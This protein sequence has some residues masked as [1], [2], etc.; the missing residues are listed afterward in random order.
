MAN[1]DPGRHVT[2]TRTVGWKAG[3]ECYAIYATSGLTNGHPHDPSQWMKKPCAVLD[4]FCGSGT[5]GVVAVQ[6][7]RR[8]IGIELNLEYCAMA[9]R[10][11]ENPEP[12]AEIPDA[13]GQMMFEEML[14][15]DGGA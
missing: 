3:C 12:V 6:L 1:R 10:R 5:T 15:A 4:P 13:E 14:T 2:Q 7:G 11:I 8:F 9:R